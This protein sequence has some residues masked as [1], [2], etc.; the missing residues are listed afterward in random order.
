MRTKWGQNF[1][2]HPPTMRRIA[3]ALE[4]APGDAVLEIGPGRGALTQCLSE[5]AGRL[6]AVELDRDLAVR[7]PAR[8]PKAEIVNAD[9]LDWPPPEVPPGTFRVIG[10]LP[11]S[12]AAPILQKVLAWT[13][14]DRAVFMVQKE[15]ADRIAA[16]AG[17]KAFGILSLAVQSRATT[18]TLFDVP[19]RAF[20]PPPRVTSTVLRFR[21]RPV[22]LFREEA[23]FFNV[24]KAGFA[25]RRKT[26]ANN[27]AGSFSK[28]R[29]AVEKILTRCG[30][31]PRARAEVVSLPQ[32]VALAEAIGS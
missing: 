21:R 24:V 14:W 6:V 12:A 8:F 2:A 29:E 15:V 3:E 1:L 27:L 28:D 4:L 13:G 23:A 9:F 25:Q 31:D 5:K 30:V 32:W 18:E 20:N 26:L 7:L 16:P 22:P 17:T 11:Y 10:N 19:P